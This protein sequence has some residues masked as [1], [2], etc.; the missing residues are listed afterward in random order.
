MP[1]YASKATGTDAGTTGNESG[2]TSDAGADTCKVGDIVNF[3]GGK[4]Y[5]NANAASGTAL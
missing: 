1:K 3:T 4:H 2:G 5:T